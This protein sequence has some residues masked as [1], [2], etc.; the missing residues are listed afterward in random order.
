MRGYVSFSR[1]KHNRKKLKELGTQIY[2]NSRA[3]QQREVRM[4]ALKTANVMVFVV[5]IL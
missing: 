4:S 1:C 2:R 3:D 5:V